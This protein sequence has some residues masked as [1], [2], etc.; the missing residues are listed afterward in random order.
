[1]GMDMHNTLSAHGRVEIRGSDAV[2]LPDDTI[3]RIVYALTTLALTPLIRHIPVE[4]VFNS[5]GELLW[6]PQN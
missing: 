3:T 2:V 6:P 4:A 5:Q 1:M